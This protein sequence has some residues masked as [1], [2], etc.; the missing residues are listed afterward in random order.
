MWNLA[1]DE[2][3]NGRHVVRAV[4]RDATATSWSVSSSR[5]ASSCEV[6]MSSFESRISVRERLSDDEFAVRYSRLETRRWCG[7]PTHNPMT[8]SISHSTF[9]I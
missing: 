1:A 6:R 7:K 2:V 9:E 8:S 4:F 3:P 5:R